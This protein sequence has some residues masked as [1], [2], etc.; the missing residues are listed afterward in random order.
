[1]QTNTPET[2]GQAAQ[3]HVPGL[4]SANDAPAPSDRKVPSV[5]RVLEAEGC[6]VI[7]FRFR[8]GQELREHKAAW[9]IT[10]QCL[11]GALEFGWQ[12]QQITL[13]PGQMLYLPKME[14]HWVR[15]EQDAVLGLQMH[16]S[17]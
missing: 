15:A 9:P 17:S 8:P 10:V 16:T 4:F 2:F 1:M 11:E 5:Q 3:Q 12:G 6:N 14:P 7:L 13:T